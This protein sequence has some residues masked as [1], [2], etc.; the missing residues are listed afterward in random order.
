MFTSVPQFV[1]TAEL[2]S[3]QDGESA[4]TQD[5]SDMHVEKTVHDSPFQDPVYL[6]YSMQTKRQRAPSNQV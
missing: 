4:K 2:F 3:L 6:D 5:V 1:T